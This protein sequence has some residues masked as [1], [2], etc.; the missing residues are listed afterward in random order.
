MKDLFR[1][2]VLSRSWQHMVKIRSSFYSL[3]PQGLIR[4]DTLQQC[5][6]FFFD[7]YVHPF[8][9]SILLLCVSSRHF[10]AFFS[11]NAML[12][13]VPIKCFVE[14]L[15]SSVYPNHLECVSGCLSHLAMTLINSCAIADFCCT[16]IMS[17]FLENTFRTVALPWKCLAAL[18]RYMLGICMYS[19]QDPSWVAAAVRE[20]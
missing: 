9:C 19:V 4:I 1:V 6:C 10:A 17:Q 15:C 2:S 20:G 13:A 3:I 16:E 14:V 11:M 12:S 8:S 18:Q 7:S 5:S